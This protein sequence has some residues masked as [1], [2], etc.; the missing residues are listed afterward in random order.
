MSDLLREIKWRRRKRHLLGTAT[1]GFA[2]VAFAAIAVTTRYIVNEAPTNTTVIAESP[3]A[4]PHPNAVVQPRPEM[5]I[6]AR[7][8]DESPVFQFDAET[9]RMHHIGWVR[10]RHT[11]PIDTRYLRRQQQETFQAV[12]HREP[13]PLSL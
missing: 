5:R 11:I 1:A 7:V 10:S 13:S 6:L 3:A 8:L 12:L 9:Q 4:Q 2:L